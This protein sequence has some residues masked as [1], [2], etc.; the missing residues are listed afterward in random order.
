MKKFYLPLTLLVFLAIAMTPNAKG[1]G[2]QPCGNGATNTAGTGGPG[3]AKDGDPFV[4]YTGNEYR[5]IQDLNVWGGVGEHQLTWSRWANS[6]FVSGANYFGDGHNWR[7]EYQWEMADAAPSSSGAAQKEII[8]PEGEDNIFTQNS[9]TNTTW[10]SHRPVEDTLYQSVSG[11]N[12]FYLQRK[13]G[14]RYHFTKNTDGSGNIYY[15]MTDFTDSAQN[16]YTLTYNSAHEVTQITEPGGRYLQVNYTNVSL[17]KVDFTTFATVATVPAGSQYTTLTVTD[18]HAYRYLR[19]LGA[20]DGWGN[21]AEVQFYDIH[22]NLLSGTPFG[23]SPP[24]A[25]GRDF[26]KAFDGNPST[27]FDYSQASGGFCGIDLGAGNA[28]VIGSVRFYPRVGFEKRMCGTSTWNSS[29]FGQFQGSNQAP[30]TLPV[31]ASVSTND[32]R[33]VTYNYTPFNDTTMPYVYQTL[34]SVNYDDGTQA[35]YTYGQVLPSTHPLIA[36][37]VDP[38]YPLAFKKSKT[39]YFSEIG[40]ALGEIQ[41]QSNYDTGETLYTL[42]SVSG[43]LHE[44]TVQRSTGGLR[45]YTQWAPSGENIG[46]ADAAGATVAPNYDTNG[47]ENRFTDGKGNL[48]TWT[49]S[50]FD[51]PTVAT[52]PDGSS[53]HWTRDSLDLPLTVK[54]QLSRTTTLTRDS[55][56]RVTGIAYPDASVENFTYNG[57]GQVLTHRLRNGQTVSAAY[58]TTGLQT[59]TTDPL[60][61]IT[62]YA[63]DS[64]GRLTSKTDARGNTTSDQYNSRGQITQ[65]TYADGSTHGY[66]YDTF[67]NKLTDTDELGHTTTYT[68]DTFN[69]CTSVTDALGRTT[70]YVFRSNYFVE[71]KPDRV[72]YPSGKITVN[73]YDLED[74]LLTQTTG[75][76]TAD[77]ATTSYAYDANYNIIRTTDP[78]GN[79]WTYAYDVRNRKTSQT[80]PL[81][82]TT[83]YTYDATGNVLTVTRPD[84]GVTTNTYDTMHR[85]LTTTD[86]KGETTTM[87]YDAS[88]N[89]LTT[90]DARSNTYTFTYDALNRKLTMQYPDGSAE[91]YGYDAVGNLVSYTTRAGQVKTST[92]DN[93]NREVSYTW[94][95]GTPG[96]TRTYDAAG[97]LLSSAN[98]A[99]TSS[100]TYDNGNQMLS[101]TQTNAN[102]GTPWTLAYGYNADGNRTGVTYPSGTA[103]TYGYTNRNQINAIAVGGTT[104]ASYAYDANGN[105]VSKTLA[106]GTV[107][108]YTY[109][110]ANRLTE[111]NHALGGTSL[112]KFDYGYDAMN[113]RTFEQRDS[114]V[115]DVYSYDAVDQVA[116]V[117]YDATNPSSGSTGADRTVGYTYDATGNRTAVNDSVNGNSS[118]SANNL[119]EYSSVGGSAYAYDGNGNLVSGNG[120]YIYDAQNRLLTAQVGATTDQFSYDSKNRVV[121][122]EINGTPT[123]YI[124]DGWDLIEERDGSNNVL[125]TYVHGVKQDELLTKTNSSGTV[126]YHH[127][128]LGSVTDLT[129]ATGTVV[130]KYKYDAFGKP[131]I[132]DGSGNPLTASAY[133]NRFMFTGRE[134]LAEVNLYDYRNR[135]YSADLG[136]FLQTDPLRFSA[137]D[138]NI[139]RYCGNNPINETD[140]MGLCVKTTTTVN[141]DGSTTITTVTTNPDGSTETDTMT[142]SKFVTPTVN[143]PNTLT[144]TTTTTVTTSTTVTTPVIDPTTG[145]QVT[146]TM[147]AGPTTSSTSTA[148]T[149]STGSG[150][151]PSS[152][153]TSGIDVIPPV[154]TS[155]PGVDFAEMSEA[156]VGGTGV[157]VDIN[158]SNKFVNSVTNDPTI[159]N[160]ST[161]L[162]IYQNTTS[163]VNKTVNGSGE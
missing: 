22:G 118:Y 9:T 151:T 109:D 90:T 137:G 159:T 153:S 43:N 80:D 91:H 75:Y 161:Q 138:V 61:N 145:K 38:R 128:A 163:A 141:P 74:H 157:L 32:G 102:I 51:N 20:D 149:I 8:Y 110:N 23:T 33:T 127:N 147:L 46:I 81:G 87:T 47:F 92:F 44:P 42:G 55:S 103:V 31:V 83:S 5:H 37:C 132:T 133:S 27:F 3:Q 144:I 108:G 152:S 158:A 139:Y 125:A 62:H 134:Y 129:N 50:T 98:S 113:R 105:P 155:I 97:R 162:Q 40:S 48:T 99:S 119:N 121:E 114:A 59:S 136:R 63:Y 45:T 49:K 135:V 1:A 67:G 29:N 73:T 16:D 120:I 30:T 13:N 70:Q 52:A 11:G 34:G 39:S 116:S 2:Q 150:S 21:V 86:P 71:Q 41:T 160:M 10:N 4:V 24:Y 94:S 66:T 72:I 14:F 15:L 17:N 6:R 122:R 104:L 96:V 111:V 68:Y 36:S 35:N 107:T 78:K 85:L 82:H 54:D 95:D 18:P 26:T 101:E 131:A 148:Y 84:G 79:V 19:Y 7:H 57:F 65:V 142:T 156:A 25:S 60:S 56:H 89:L 28:A 77:A 100:Y 106:N 112:A 124:Y 117:N 69:R 126:Y 123:F 154:A 140:A 64:A 115:G 58:D 146:L 93:R 53:M 130:E 76:G 12:D 88:G 143:A